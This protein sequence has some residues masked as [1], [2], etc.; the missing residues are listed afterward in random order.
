MQNEQV[1]N[2]VPW[3]PWHGCKNQSGSALM[4]DGL[5]IGAWNLKKQIERAEQVQRELEAMYA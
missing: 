3:N 2:A 5:N 1:N 4:R